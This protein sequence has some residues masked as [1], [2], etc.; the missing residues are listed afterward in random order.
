MSSTIVVPSITN[1]QS[2][3]SSRQTNVRGNATPR[4]PR[5]LED[6]NGITHLRRPREAINYPDMSEVSAESP[7]PADF[8]A[9]AALH[10]RSHTT[11]FRP[12]ASQEWL[13]SRNLD[14][15]RINWC[16]DLEQP[17]SGLRVWVVRRDDRVVGMVKIA[18]LPKEESES[19]RGAVADLPPHANVAALASMHVEPELIGGGIGRVLLSAAV[20]HLREAGYDHCILGVILENHRARRFYEAAGWRLVDTRPVGVEGVPVAT[21]RIDL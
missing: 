16:R 9:I 8:E 3:P 21:Y 20:E 11:S 18:P 10:Y 17:S 5:A 4:I 15:Y 1:E 7:E 2:I 19:S 12:F 6:A 13:D 14:D